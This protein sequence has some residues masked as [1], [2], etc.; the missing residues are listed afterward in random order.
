MALVNYSI[1]DQGDMLVLVLCYQLSSMTLSELLCFVL[2]SSCIK[3]D[4]TTSPLATPQNCVKDQCK[5]PS[6]ALL[7]FKSCAPDDS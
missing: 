7:D 1:W 4:I 2:I 3:V 5:T 6:E